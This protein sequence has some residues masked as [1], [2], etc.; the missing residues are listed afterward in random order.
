MLMNHEE[1][2]K[3]QIVN[4]CTF[5]SEDVL[6]SRLAKAWNNKGNSLLDLTN[7][8]TDLAEVIH[9]FEKAIEYYDLPHYHTNLGIALSE[10]GRDKDAI[11]EF[12]IAIE[13][14]TNQ[15]NESTG[16]DE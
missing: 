6:K 9:C 3:A 10:S 1:V 7:S 16:K 13:R 2:L 5:N 15:L 8:N 12:D 14:M 11:K 4:V